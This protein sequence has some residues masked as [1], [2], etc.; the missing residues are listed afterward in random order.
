MKAHVYTVAALSFMV[1]ATGLQAAD[2]VLPFTPVSTAVLRASSR[3]VYAHHHVYKISIDNKDDHADQYTTVFLNPLNRKRG[4]GMKFG[5]GGFMRQRPYPRPPREADDWLSAD[6]RHDVRLAIAMGLDG[7]IVNLVDDLGSQWWQDTKNL[8]RAAQQVDPAFRIIIGAGLVTYRGDGGADFLL[9]LAKEIDQFPNV[10]R[11]GGKPALSA[12]AANRRPASFWK[13]VHDSWQRAGLNIAFAP[14]S[15]GFWLK[16]EDGRTSWLQNNKPFFDVLMDSA[17]CGTYDQSV[18]TARERVR[19]VFA[20]G[21]PVWAQVIR[22]QDSRMGVSWDAANSRLFR[23]CWDIAIHDLRSQ[24]WTQIFTWNDYK[25]SPVRPSTGTQYSFYDLARY[26]IQWFKTRRRPE[27]TKDVLYYF[28]RTQSTTAEP[29]L[30]EQKKKFKIVGGPYNEIELL[31]F[32]TKPG[33]LEI[34]VHGKTKR[35]KA[36]PGITSFRVPV[37]E[38]TPEF[39][40]VRNGDTAIH[41]RSK[42]AISNDI[43]YENHLYYGG[44][45][46]RERDLLRYPQAETLRANLLLHLGLNETWGPLV[47][48]NS[49]RRQAGV[50]TDLEGVVHAA[51]VFGNGLYFHDGPTDAHRVR[52][53]S[54]VSVPS[55]GFT[56]ALW[57]KPE[58]PVRGNLVSLSGPNLNAE[59]SG[60]GGRI[61]FDVSGLDSAASVQ[62]VQ[63]LPAEGW[64]FVAATIAPTGP[65][66]VVSDRIVGSSEERISV[67]ATRANVELGGG[68]AG[69]IDEVMLFDRVLT[70]RELQSIREYTAAE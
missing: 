18:S 5:Y 59:L 54:G 1:L 26:Y 41:S 36:G 13:G 17:M 39:K 24:D 10:L 29:D 51:G 42:W 63:A 38:G 43:I 22:A 21:V 31:A 60:Q 11:I 33:T 19:N 32:L 53:K 65:R 30:D 4:G 25:E 48:D 40:L 70:L 23:Q 37:S 7:F 44:S 62:S 8:I 20:A 57:V 68:Y 9:A 2:G 35:M 66:L 34:D 3:K 46:T 50:L 14:C 56:I 47:Y 15:H 49:E 12:W 16:G 52:M 27:I 64:S 58:H 55:R 6:N 45:S 69:R 28:H 67:P 61:L